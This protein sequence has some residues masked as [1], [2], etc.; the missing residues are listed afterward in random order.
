M[1]KHSTPNTNREVI[2][3]GKYLSEIITISD[4][5]GALLHKV[6]KPIMVEVYARDVMQL[7]VGAAL[8]S[9]PVA[10]TEEVW[11]LGEN[12][13][14]SNIIALTLVSISFTSLFI[15]YNFYKNH[16]KNHKFQFFKRVALIYI[17]SLFISWLIL[18][19]IGQGGS[20]EP[21]IT[22]K[23]MIIISFPASM[24]AAIADMIK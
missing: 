16:F 6:I 7:I 17:I 11:N 21:L 3:I 20:A 23:K 18:T 10:F 24:S 14:W 5:K 8:L 19:L 4:K 12:L 13:A 2:R 22:L 9:T 15:Y 1:K